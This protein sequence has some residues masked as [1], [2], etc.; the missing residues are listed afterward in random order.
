MAKS[1]R[2]KPTVISADLVIHARDNAVAVR[3]DRIVAVGA[4]SAVD[5]H[6]TMSFPDGVLLPGLIDLHAHPAIEGSKHGVDPD[7]HCLERGVTTVL[8]QG[9][10]GAENWR[11]YFEHTIG[12]CRTRVRLAINLSRRGESTA[13]G[14]LSNID[15]ADV[16]RCIAA[17]ED[18][19]EL[20]PAVAC[21]IDRHDTGGAGG[22]DPRELLRRAVAV[23][24]ATGR[25]ILLGMR[26]T[27]DLSFDE[28]LSVL[29]PGDVVTYLFRSKPHCIVE[30]GRIHPALWEAKKRGVLFDVGH[31]AGSFDFSVAEV[32][33]GEGFYPDT[34]STD[35]HRGTMDQ[36]PAHDLPRTMSKLAAA[37]MPVDEVFTAA[38]ATPARLLGLSDEIG[39]LQ[40]GA[41]AD[42]TVLQW[43]DQ[44]VQLTDV[45][46]CHRQDHELQ[47]VFTLRG[48]EGC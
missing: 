13:T 44:P 8:S 15:D 20:I 6:R 28:Q 37:G 32:A 2:A 5:A 33:L 7:E 25:W 46:D 1:P 4:D 34:I 47:P 42:I 41:C 19:G 21:N 9:D 11:A 10:A 45:N 26:S 36:T 38:T 39:A 12:R 18:G 48:A 23:A 40:A 35:F 3:G 14:A 24:E 22:S 27:E 43:S 30:D 29:R 17:I 31:G 16:D